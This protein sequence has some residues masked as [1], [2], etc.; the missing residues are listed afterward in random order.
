M[1]D[2]INDEWM[3][4]TVKIINESGKIGTGFLIKSESKKILVTNKHVLHETQVGREAVNV[5][6]LHLNILTGGNIRRHQIQFSLQ[7]NDIKLWKEHPDPNVDVLAIDVS[8]I[9]NSVANLSTKPMSSSLICTRSQLQK[10]NIASGT[11]IVILGYPT[12]TTLLN[13]NRPFRLSGSIMNDMDN[14]IV[15]PCFNPVT[16]RS[17]N[18]VI[19]GFA[20]ESNAMIGSSGSPVILEPIFSTSGDENVIGKQ[21][22]PLLLGIVSEERFEPVQ[23]EGMQEQLTRA[24]MTIVQTSESIIDVIN[25]FQ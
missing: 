2:P 17:E 9:C 16:Q 6:N 21:L 20:I 1:P 8:T 22:P 14:P 15:H 18:K 23:L 24:H 12:L 7:N 10:F 11:K 3:N 19:G 13:N 5:V 4:A 25:L